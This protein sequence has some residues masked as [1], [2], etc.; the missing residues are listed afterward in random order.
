M[1]PGARVQT[2]IE[3]FE[4]FDPHQGP[5]DTFFQAYLRAR[6]YIGSG[7]RRALTEM[8]F[9]LLR[10]WPKLTYVLNHEALPLTARWRVL[11]FLKCQGDLPEDLFTGALYHPA[12][13]DE[14]ERAFLAHPLPP[15]MPLWA[16]LS[17]PAPV[18]QALEASDQQ[19]VE[20][21]LSALNQPAPVDIRVNLSRAGLE[22]VIAV[23]KREGLEPTLTPFSPMGIRCQKR[24]RLQNLEMW[25]QGWLDIQDEGSQVI[26]LL[27]DVSPGQT[28]LDYCAG[29][30]GKTLALAEMLN[31]QGQVLATDISPQRLDILKERQQRLQTPCIE[32]A[33]LE[34]L[35]SQQFDR[36]LVDAPCSG[37]GTWRRRPDLKLSFSEEVVASLIKTQQQILTRAQ[38]HVKPGGRLIYA[39]C[40]LLPQEN[41]D[42]VTWFLTHFKDFQLVPIR[43][44]CQQKLRVIPKG[45]ADVLQLDPYHHQ[46]DG[47]FVSVF[48]RL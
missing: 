23:L 3:I 11:T 21:I 6:S 34:T 14:V 12:S 10:T 9:D 42:Q 20:A 5:F 40:S 29:A 18:F 43:P 22:P 47:F 31:G 17:T 46:T 25:R 15:E 36:V 37:V 35:T 30:G 19:D 16:Q 1:R 26:A 32:V 27:C 48:E 24:Q 45:C 38:S 2:V 13:L 7:D 8:C 28:I 39:T 33:P 4:G 44:L 41:Q